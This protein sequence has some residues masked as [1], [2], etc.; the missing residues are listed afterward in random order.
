[1]TADPPPVDLPSVVTGPAGVAEVIAIGDE[2]TSGARTDTNSAWLSRRLAELGIPTRFHTTVG[3]AV[4]DNVLA[5]R[6]AVRRADVVVT[7]GGLG[8]TRDD[9]TREALAEAAGVALEFRPEAWE[10]VVQTFTRRGRVIPERNRVQAM[11]P[12]G[13]REIFNPEGTAPGIELE[14]SRAGQ[15]ACHVFAL[16]GV[17]AEMKRMFEETVTPRLLGGRTSGFHIRQR[18]LKFFGTGESDMEER[19]GDRIARGREPL[20]GITVSAATISLRVTAR[21]RSET[22]CERQI[23]EACREIMERVGEFH[24]GEGERFEQQHAVERQLRERGQSLMVAE[25]GFAAP[26]GDWFAALG[27]TPA[28]RGGIS[29]ANLEDLLRISGQA[30]VP[31][32]IRWWQGRLAAN[33][34]LIVD[35]Y[36]SLGEDRGVRSPAQEVRFWVADPWG[37]VLQESHMLGGHPS[38]LHARIAKTALQIFRRVL[39][40][41]A[42]RDAPA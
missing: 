7:T 22:E 38:V 8:P 5:F 41:G 24:F 25:L 26:L 12:A 33:W 21:G 4:G 23:E 29:L 9:L 39:A 13:S 20:V 10:H 28:F 36:P 3:D 15:P 1:M 19:L 37:G 35:G 14:F 18:V 2:L 32:A 40:A 42:A 17:P 16:P 34:G 6:A 27:D 30:S 31:E 11:F